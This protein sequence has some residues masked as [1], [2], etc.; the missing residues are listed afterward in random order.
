MVMVLRDHHQSN[1]R[2]SFQF[3]KVETQLH[4][5]VA[6]RFLRVV[7]KNI[8]HILSSRILKFNN[9]FCRLNQ[10]LERLELSQLQPCKSLTHHLIRHK[11]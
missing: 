3:C 6:T 9:L 1:R 10:E 2:L 5:Y 8:D 7:D 4:R 11:L